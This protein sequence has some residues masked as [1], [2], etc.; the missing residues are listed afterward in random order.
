VDYLRHILLK[1]VL[2][3]SGSQESQAGLHIAKYSLKFFVLLLQ[4]LLGNL[5]F[6]VE[7]LELFLIEDLHSEVKR[8]QTFLRCVLSKGLHS[9][10]D[11][12]VL[13]PL[14][15]PFLDLRV[16]TFHIKLDSVVARIQHKNRHALPC[17][18]ELHDLFHLEAECVRISVV[19]LAMTYML[20]RLVEL[21][22]V[23]LLA[24]QELTHTRIGRQSGLSE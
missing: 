10:H 8:A 7:L 17:A 16:R 21:H 13:C 1:S 11:I 24:R 18:A 12:S 20:I 4:V 15:E 23:V 3:S 2:D 6:D 14:L 5:D 19:V 22:Q 9:P